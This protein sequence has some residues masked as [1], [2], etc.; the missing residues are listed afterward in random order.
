MNYKEIKD[1]VEKNGDWHEIMTVS[2]LALQFGYDISA[3]GADM[4]EEVSV[5]IYSDRLIVSAYNDDN[6]ILVNCDLDDTR[7]W[8]DWNDTWKDFILS[9]VPENAIR[10]AILRAAEDD[11]DVWKKD[12]PYESLAAYLPCGIVY[13]DILP[14]A[15]DENS[16]EWG[17][18]VEALIDNIAQE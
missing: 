1:V 10:L 17:A 11:V 14:I 9:I 6:T 15:Y 7:G 4:A 18:R 3:Y 5:V 8:D 12:N 13:S 2:E 16:H